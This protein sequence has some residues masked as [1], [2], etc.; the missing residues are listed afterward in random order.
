MVT[1]GISRHGGEKRTISYLSMSV[2]EIDDSTKMHAF[3]I[4]LALFPLATITTLAAPS[5]NNYPDAFPSPIKGYKDPLITS[6]DP[7][8]PDNSQFLDLP[9]LQ[10]SKDDYRL[11]PQIPGTCVVICVMVPHPSMTKVS[12]N[13]MYDNYLQYACAPS[14]HD[15]LEHK[16]QPIKGDLKYPEPKEED[17]GWKLVP[18]ELPA[19]SVVVTFE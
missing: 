8:N 11:A 9:A 5:P 12:S 19:N 7:K 2:L 18:E 6:D 13:A 15:E 10:A 17:E 1:A 3:P 14:C 16:S 4:L